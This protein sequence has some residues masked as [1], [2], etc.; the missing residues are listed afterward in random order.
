MRYLLR[1]IL[2]ANSPPM[3]L[4]RAAVAFCTLSTSPLEPIFAQEREVRVE[5]VEPGEIQRLIHKLG[6][7]NNVESSQAS[8]RLAEIKAQALPTLISTLADPDEDVRVRSQAASVLARGLPSGAEAIPAMMQI[9]GDRSLN[10]RLRQTVAR[11]LFPI[12]GLRAVD[13][14]AKGSPDPINEVPTLIT[15]LEDKS[16]DVEVRAG[17]AMAL[18]EIGPAAQAALPSLLEALR[19]DSPRIRSASLFALGTI[20]ANSPDIVEPLI[21][22]LQDEDENVREFAAGALGE[23]KGNSEPIV[24]ALLTAM[25]DES[26]WF[27]R[28]VVRAFG[29]MDAKIPGVVPALI[30]ALDDE[31]DWVREQ[32]A[33]ALGKAGPETSEVIPALIEA[34]S[35]TDPLV[36]WHCARALG[37]FGEKARD[38][39]P[40]LTQAMLTKNHGNEAYYAEPDCV[41]ALRAV[42]AD[43]TLVVPPLADALNSDNRRDW[44]G[45]AR[46][47]GAIGAEGLPVL[48]AAMAKPDSERCHE[49]RNGLGFINY[50]LDTPPDLTP[51]SL[52]TLLDYYRAYLEE[53]EGRE[54][55][56][57]TFVAQTKAAIAYLES[58]E[59]PSWFYLGAYKESNSTRTILYLAVTGVITVALAAFLR[60][61]TVR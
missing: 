8:Q 9:L 31:H 5:A 45:A 61:W 13:P 48:A 42:G 37:A 18:R 35:D 44:A 38:A 12:I 25:D 41:A 19:E 29:S 3:M 32:A 50:P 26:W 4:L 33:E 39:I 58:L 47:L 57:P 21:V 40:A 1:Q 36:Q 54:H 15:V 23:H 53:L 52:Q 34:L 17:V 20:G 22:A 49:A 51:E 11:G 28:E 46:A 60:R 27:R 24:A 59:P 2:G 56:Q 14:D 10:T 43:L 55:V 30:R 7:D 16:E 6:S